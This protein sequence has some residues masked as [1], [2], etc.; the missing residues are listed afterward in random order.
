MPVLVKSKDSWGNALSVLLSMKEPSE[1]IENR[2]F[3]QMFCLSFFLELL[4]QGAPSRR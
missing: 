2:T 3:F 4:Q 1:D